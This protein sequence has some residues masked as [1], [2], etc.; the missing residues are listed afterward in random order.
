MVDLATFATLSWRDSLCVVTA[1]RTDGSVHAS[2]VN[3]GVLTHPVTGQP[4]SFEAPI[5]EDLAALWAYSGGGT[6]APRGFQ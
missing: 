2:V 6:S 5:P 3:A 4:L 1:T